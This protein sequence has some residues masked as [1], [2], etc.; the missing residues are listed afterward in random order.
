MHAAL[1]K[2]ERDASVE[3]SELVQYTRAQLGSLG[4]DLRLLTRNANQQV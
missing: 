2:H 3:V 4:M 1:V